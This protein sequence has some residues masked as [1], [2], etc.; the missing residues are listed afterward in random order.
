MLNDEWEPR[1][2]RIVLNVW[3]DYE[4]EYTGERKQTQYDRDLVDESHLVFGLF[5]CVCGKYSR[6]EVMR[7]HDNNPDNLHCYKLPSDNDAAVLAFEASS[8]I[9]MEQLADKEEVWERIKGAAEEYIAAHY[10]ITAEPQTIEKEKVYLTLGEDLRT[11][12]NAVGNMIRGVDMLADQQMG[13]RCMLLPLL[14]GRGICDCDYYIAMF[15]NVLDAQS[16]NEF[17]KAYNGLSRYKH[18]AEIAPFQKRE[19]RLQS[20][21]LKMRSPTC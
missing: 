3:E 10:P 14:D 1:G 15:N 7:A 17:V 18:P 12:E 11:E 16:S 5:R 9:I 8:G 21:T 20:M 4:A 6:E 19:V 13:L 2:V